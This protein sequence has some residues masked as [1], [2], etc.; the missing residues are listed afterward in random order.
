MQ[1]SGE[2]RVV[3]DVPDDL[4]QAYL[5]QK[6]IAIDTELQGLR[7]GRDQ[8]C[9]V[10]ICDRESR[11]C[12]VQPRPPEAPPNLKH[13]LTHPKTTKIFHYAVTDVAFLQQSL[14][15]HV[16][17]FRC[18]KVMSKMIRTYTDSHSLKDLVAEMVGIELEKDSQLTNWFRRDLSSRQLKYAAN[19]VLHLLKVFDSLKQMLKERGPLPSGITA[20]EMNEL[21]QAAL[22]A[23]VE[24][25][26]NGYGDRENGWNTS[27]FTH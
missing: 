1:G 18:T 23:L 14:S 22:P 12:L 19:D 20:V 4:L 24:L 17:P 26:L 10:Q 8:V 27:V 15:I 16:H 7:L 5:A 11:V 3:P 2:F 13:L 9:L 25:I 6:E 21:S